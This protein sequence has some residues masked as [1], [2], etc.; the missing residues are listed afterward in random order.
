MA[1]ALKWNEAWVRSAPR[2]AF[3]AP[4]GALLPVKE[5][6]KNPALAG[7][8]RRIAAEGKAAFY[9]GAIADDVVET[10]RAAGGPSP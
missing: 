3:F 5:T 1:R 10:A 6:V 8:V 4:G 7:T 2:Y 9:R